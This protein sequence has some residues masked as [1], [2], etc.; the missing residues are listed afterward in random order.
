MSLINLFIYLFLISP[1]LRDV[2]ICLGSCPQ[3]LLTDQ[4]EIFVLALEVGP[5]VLGLE[6]VS[7][8]CCLVLGWS[9]SVLIFVL[10]V[11][12]CPCSHLCWS[13]LVFVLILGR[14]VLVLVLILGVSFCPCLCTWESVLDL[15]LVLVFSSCPS[16]CPWGQSS[17]PS[18]RVNSCFVFVLGGQVLVLI[19]GV[20]SCP[21][22]CLFGSVIVIAVV[23][24]VSPCPWEFSPF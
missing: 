7:P 6:E 15:V 16:L 10:G 2:N 9:V 5:C 20:S 19:L 24:G 3:G 4:F 1:I 18:F 17:S 22:L 11:S 23:L 14:S 12:S 13:D 21:F 8:Y